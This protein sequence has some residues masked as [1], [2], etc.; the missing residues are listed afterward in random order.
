MDGT[1]LMTIERNGSYY[2]DVIHHPNPTSGWW[3]KLNFYVGVGPLTASI[4]EISLKD[5]TNTLTG[6]GVDSWNFTGFDASSYDYIAFDSTNLNILFTNAPALG[7]N[8][9]VVQLEQVIS[10]TISVGESYRVKFDYNITGDIN[11]YY[12]N[13]S[14]QG[15]R[16]GSLS[17]TGTYDV[18]HKVGELDA[19]ENPTMI[20]AGELNSTFV[21]Y[22]ENGDVNDL[23]TV[24]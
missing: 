10:N 24:V 13:P 22:V 2:G 16:F 12:F 19:S 1:G 4:N 3:N 20:A 15:F 7:A 8:K 18:L 23:A 11:G 17:G 21:I 5:L 6:G 9:E 14:G